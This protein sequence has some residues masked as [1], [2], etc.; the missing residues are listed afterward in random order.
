M[1]NADA[2]VSDTSSMGNS[3]DWVIEFKISG[4]VLDAAAKSAEKAGVDLL[5]WC[6]MNGKLN[7]KEYL[8]WAMS[9]YSLPV[10]DADFFASVPDLSLWKKLRAM[11]LWNTSLVPLAE[12]DGCLLIGCL[13][14]P[15][16]LELE[17]NHRF[18]LAS[19]RHL[20]LFWNQLDHSQAKSSNGSKTNGEDRA[21]VT[22]VPETTASSESAPAPEA[23][24]TSATS[25]TTP[26]LGPAQTL[27]R[28]PVADSEPV[29]TEEEITLPTA[30]E[31]RGEITF[32][33]FAASLAGDAPAKIEKEN[34][35]ENEATVTFHGAPDGILSAT[36]PPSPEAS[37]V[38]TVDTPDLSF[39][40]PDG[41]DLNSESILPEIKLSPEEDSPNLNDLP[42]AT[43]IVNLSSTPEPAPESAP[44]SA[45]AEALAEEQTE[46]LLTTPQSLAEPE[47]EP[48]EHTQVTGVNEI[49]LSQ[50]IIRPVT[51]QGL[52]EC[53][54]KDELGDMTVQRILGQFEGGMVLL[55]ENE[56]LKPWKFNQLPVSSESGKLAE[57]ELQSPSIFRV[58]NRTRLPYHGYVTPS[59]INTAFFNAFH[60]GE[61]PKHVTLTPI[62]SDNNLIGMLLAISS[63]E[64]DF[65]T[66]LTPVQNLSH[67]FALHFRRLQALNAA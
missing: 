10:V 39:T 17:R 11:G 3:P 15:A 31:G 50:A 49:Q 9:K 29:A 28:A 33:A 56:K 60:A 2:S 62:L 44:E 20:L 52:E 5:R 41:L 26:N 46:E 4:T 57:I 23:T 16:A 27:T 59:A 18:V 58:V 53:K 67:E 64:L 7:E 32:A 36:P 6:L 65:K 42:S 66:T 22:S 61:L 48:E 21:A 43:A 30:E 19:A 45:P 8:R 35:V 12:W 1:L 40:R 14:P 34:Q 51:S 47:P 24:A 55:C 54:S 37:A 13:E 63:H 25:A 38:D